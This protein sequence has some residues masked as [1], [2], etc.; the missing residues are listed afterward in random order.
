VVGGWVGIPEGIAHLLPGH[1]GEI[2]SQWLEP[3]IGHLPVHEHSA[4]VEW[5]LMG[6]SVSLAGLGAWF[7]YD[8]YLVH[9]EVPKALA[10][11]L[12]P[13]YKV[14]FNKY[15]VDEIYFAWLINPL[16]RGSQALWLYID[17]NFIDK[18]T[19]IAG[20]L[21]TGAASFVKTV[22]NGKA[23]SYALYMALGV[24]VIMTFVLL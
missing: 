14:S 23:Q 22:Q 4:M 2:F 13:V 7:A 5:A 24:V 11:K 6:V 12:G 16:V 15:Y 1:V 9:K 3:V 21:A 19:Y 17:V 18:M 10:D 8:A 20:D